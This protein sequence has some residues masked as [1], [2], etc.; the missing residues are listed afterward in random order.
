MSAIINHDYGTPQAVGIPPML[1][2]PI[3]PGG[4]ATIQIYDSSNALVGTTTAKP[5]GTWRQ[6]FTLNDGIYT[7]KFTGAFRPV[8]IGYSS[9]Y[10]KPV[11]T[12]I[13]TITISTPVTPETGVTGPT[14]P[15][16]PKGTTGEQGLDGA[17]GIKGDAGATGVTGPAGVDGVIGVDGD[18]GATGSAGSAGA[19]G[20]TGAAGAAGATGST[21]PAGSTGDTGST[22]PTGGIGISDSCD[23]D[24]G[25]TAGKWDDGL[26]EWTPSTSLCDAIDEVNETLFYLAPADAQSM[27]GDA[28]STFTYT[29]RLSAGNVNYEVGATAGSTVDYIVKADFLLG[30]P[31][32][33]TTFNKSDEGT[34][35]WFLN[36]AT[37]DTVDLAANFDEGERSGDQSAVPWVS[38]DLSITDVGWYN[39]FPKWQ[40]GTA[41]VNVQATGLQQGYNYITLV[42]DGISSTQTTSTLDIFYDNDPGPDPAVGTPIITEGATAM[43]YL[44]G[45]KMYDRGSTFNL[46]VTALFCFNNVFHETSPLTY[47]STSSTMDSGNIDYDDGSVSGVDSPPT[48]GNTMI[49]ANKTLTVPSSDIRSTDARLTV[50]PRD[51]YNS[52]ASSTS[53]SEDRLIDAFSTNSTDLYEYFDDE[54]RRLPTGPYDATGISITGQWNSSTTLPGNEA[55]VYNGRLYYPTIN[56]SGYLPTGPNYSTFSGDQV[57]YRAFY[58]AGVPHSSGQ[59]EFANLADADIGGLGTGDINVEIKLPTQ[60][61]WLDLGTAYSLG[62]FG[63][64]DG[65]GCR[66]DQSGNDWYWTCG[67]IS[68]ANS[69]Y[70]IIVRVTFRNPNDITQIRELGW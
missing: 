2:V 4:S 37:A 23:L 70:M 15:A 51:P 35:R 64:A 41:R 1:V 5:D 12:Q 10:V 27:D 29:G 31:N 65:D 34:F 45:V 11:S 54:D 20:A 19:T 32:P 63:G 42:H 49:V 38:G 22:G 60:T 43:R 28:L 58:D 18:A 26:L 17:A 59:L 48:I 57:Y 46:A 9:R 24:L 53:A 55:Q 52:Y 14:G 3:T 66:T 21:G 69:G 33:T 7:V 8:G 40:L 30:S 6:S 68:T 39:N 25:S 47:S 67:T 62:G 13:N 61:G 36:G 44:S 56:F 50:T 16:G